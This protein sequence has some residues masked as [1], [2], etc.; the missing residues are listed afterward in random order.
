MPQQEKHSIDPYILE[1]IQTLF[2]KQLLCI[3]KAIFG[4]LLDPGATKQ[5]LIT[6]TRLPCDLNHSS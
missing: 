1:Q 2:F 3:C 4:L 6:A 5:H